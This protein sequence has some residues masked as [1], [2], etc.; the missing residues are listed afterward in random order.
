MEKIKISEL[1]TFDKLRRK[2]S[3]SKNVDYEN[4]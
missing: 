1:P 2:Y 4:N 3:K